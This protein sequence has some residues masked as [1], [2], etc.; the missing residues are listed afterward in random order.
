MPSAIVIGGGL[1]GLASAVALGQSEFR[2]DLFEARGFLGGRA[3]SY[4]APGESGEV[5]DNCQHVL[6]RCCV[7]LMDFYGR[8]GVADR[9]EFHQQ[10]FFI[11]PGG[12]TS[13]LQAGGLPAP[14]HFTGSFWDLK[15][16]RIVDKLAIARALWAIRSEHAKREDLDQITMLDWLR[17]KGQTERAIRRF[18]NPVLVSAVNEDLDR[19]AA[20]HGFQVFWLGFLAHANSYEMGIPAVPLADLYGPQA[21]QRISTVRL[22]ERAAVERVIIEDG[23]VRGVIAGGERYQADYYV[24][25]LPFE[26]VPS[27]I[28]ELD[29]NM[30]KFE[31]SPITGIHLWFDRSLTDLP[32]AT[33]LDRTIQWM[34]NKCGGRYLQLV[35]SASRSLVEMPRADVIALAVRELAEFFP[36]AAE[37]KLEKAHVVK[38]IRATFSAR[39][40]LEKVRPLSTTKFSNLFLAGDWTRS[41]WPATMEGA[42]RSGYLAAEAITRGSGHERKFLLPDIA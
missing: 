7:N 38:E 35:V 30:E 36:L 5:I 41:G 21:W 22:H 25:A 28:P 11:E 13:S 37:A 20:S 9:I 4:P 24:C 10:F 14:L 39:P 31:H 17:E 15:F 8:L 40:G 19:M 33:L 12:R 42:A 23:A 2:V 6:L 34:F 18:W 32:H 1:A 27:A 3:T 29:L 16:L 26:R